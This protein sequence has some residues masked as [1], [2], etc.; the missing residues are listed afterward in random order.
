M[1]ACP[2]KGK[3]SY[4]FQ[5]FM[6]APF[7]TFLCGAAILE[8]KYVQGGLERIGPRTLWPREDVAEEQCEQGSMWPRKNGVLLQCRNQLCT[9]Q[10]Q[11]CRQ[12]CR[13]VCKSAKFWRR[14]V[15]GVLKGVLLSTDIMHGNGVSFCI[16]LLM[17]GS[18]R[19]SVV[20]AF[21]YE[22]SPWSV[23]IVEVTAST[24]HGITKKW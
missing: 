1:F 23:S 4:L 15:Q 17:S 22:C 21:T 8:M 16:W 10:K 5:N 19:Q 3:K 13:Q 2:F 11:V 6:G 12:S 20:R 14:S 18:Q 9:K 7:Q 24:I